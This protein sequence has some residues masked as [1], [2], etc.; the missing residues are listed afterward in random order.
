[1]TTP[2]IQPWERSRGHP[3]SGAGT[4]PGTGCVPSLSLQ[5]PHAAAPALGNKDAATSMSLPGA[6]CSYCDGPSAVPLSPSLTRVYW[7]PAPGHHGVTLGSRD[8]VSL[9]LCQPGVSAALSPRCPPCTYGVPSGPVGAPS[10]AGPVAMATPPRRRRAF[11]WRPLLSQSAPQRPE[12]RHGGAGN[13]GEAEAE[14]E[15]AAAVAVSFCAVTPGRHHGG[16]GFA[17]AAGLGAHR[18]LAAAHVREGAGAGK[19][20]DGGVGRWVPSSV[21]AAWGIQPSR[22]RCR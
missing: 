18:A 14:A 9:Q 21:S 4:G 22:P 5:W 16:R 12:S 8:V 7:H 3:G 20:G 11:P 1:M 10:P 19:G 15:A 6:A 13:T 2:R 17:G